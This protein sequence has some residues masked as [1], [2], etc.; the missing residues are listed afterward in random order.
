M[1]TRKHWLSPTALDFGVLRQSRKLGTTCTEKFW[2]MRM[3]SMLCP[4][5]PKACKARDTSVESW[6]MTSTWRVL[7][8]V[9]ANTARKQSRVHY[10]NAAAERVGGL[11]ENKGLLLLPPGLYSTCGMET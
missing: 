3:A 6:T 5:W 7:R 10:S 11:S 8:G 2:R 4:P 9:N 1:R